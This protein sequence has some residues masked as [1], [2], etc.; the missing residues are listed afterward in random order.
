MLNQA[1]TIAYA[2]ILGAAVS[3]FAFAQSSSSGSMSSEHNTNAMS[4]G[5]NSSGSMTSGVDAHKD[6]DKASST[7]AMSQRFDVE[8]RHVER[9]LVQLVATS[10]LRFGQA[11]PR[12]LPAR[13]FPMFRELSE[14]AP[15]KGALG[16]PQAM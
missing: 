9:P 8:R 7:H 4:S 5:S 6:Q 13:A 14:L 15:C 3:S 16:C 12:R 10:A 2:M 11:P 1:K